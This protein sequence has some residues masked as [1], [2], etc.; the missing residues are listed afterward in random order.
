MER[1]FRKVRRNVRKRCGNRATS[2]YLKKNAEELLL[3]QNMDIPEYRNILYGN[4][5]MI[6]VIFGRN[7]SKFTENHGNSRKRVDELIRIGMDKLISGQLTDNPYGAKS[8]LTNKN[9]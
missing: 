2:S 4:D 5:E 9:M 1:S 8:Q 7:R 3:Y 6:P